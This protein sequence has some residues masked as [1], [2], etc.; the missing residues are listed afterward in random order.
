[1]IG[2]AGTSPATTRERWYA[3][4]PDRNTLWL[5]L[6]FLTWLHFPAPGLTMIRF[7]TTRWT[8]LR[9]RQPRPIRCD[10]S[11]GNPRRPAVRLS[12]AIGS[13]IRPPGNERAALIAEFTASPG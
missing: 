13:E 10:K 2:V 9:I 4:Q 11:T 12:V 6:L 1:M 5:A 3:L 8:F 7:L